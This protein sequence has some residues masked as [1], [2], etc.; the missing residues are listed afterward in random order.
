MLNKVNNPYEKHLRSP[1][2]S[3]LNITITYMIFGILWILTSDN[4]LAALVPTQ[5]DFY[6]ISLYKGWFYIALTSVL[7]FAL[8]YS[9]LQKYYALSDD[10]FEKV[11]VLRRTESLLNA[12]ILA[13]QK[14]ENELK[15]SQDRY[16]LILEGVNDGI[17]DWQISDNT[18]YLSPRLYEIIGYSAVISNYYP[19]NLFENLLHPL[20]KNIVMK[21]IDIYLK[22]GKGSYSREMQLLHRN[23]YYLWVNMSAKAIWDK[24]NNPIKMV[25]AISDI[26]DRKTYD[27]KIEELAFMDAI[28]K[29]P[30]KSKLEILIEPLLKHTLLPFAFI[31]FDIDHFKMI[32]DSI[33]HE[34]G[35]QLLF[36]VG[37]SLK[38]NLPDVDIVSRISG[39]EFTLI[40]PYD[41]NLDRITEAIESITFALKEPMHLY[42][43][44]FSLTASVG[45]S[46]FPEHGTTFN[47]LF[48]KSRYGDVRFKR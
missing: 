48:K 28:T 39:D 32:N 19:V 18:F 2:R 38:S 40:V 4:I 43:R 31:Y 3:A 21:E 9:R 27:H 45:V 20:E 13:H 7:L 30:N 41:G 26:S 12:R 44:E 14:S 1:L 47:A 25:G 35:D 23:G 29:L 36:R 11:S 42:D 46:L 6:R 15:I 10:L 34:L 24:E 17:F 33:G 5:S 8:I 16:R 37:Q 22:S